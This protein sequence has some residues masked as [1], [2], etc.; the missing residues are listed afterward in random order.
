[1]AEKITKL[2]AGERRVV[3]ISTLIPNEDNPKSIS[4]KQL[5]RLKNSLQELDYILP[6][7]VNQDMRII[8]G[9]QRVKALLEEGIERVEVNV[10]TLDEEHEL[11]ALLATDQTY[12]SFDRVKRQDIINLLEERGA[13]LDVLADYFNSKRDDAKALMDDMMPREAKLEGNIEYGQVIRLGRHYLICGD[14]TDPDIWKKVR[15]IGKPYMVCTSPPYLNQRDYAQWEN[16]AHYLKDMS[17]VFIETTKDLEECLVFLNIGVDRTANLPAK[18]DMILEEDCHLSFHESICWFKSQ[19]NLNVPRFKQ[20]RSH[21]LYY[22]AFQ[23]EPCLVYIRGEPHQFDPKDTNYIHE[24]FLSDVWKFTT[25]KATEGWH[26]APY[27]LELARTA[28]QC[29]SG[30]DD[31]ILDPFIG[32]GTTFYAAEECHRTCI[33]IELSPEYCELIVRD[34]NARYGQSVEGIES[35]D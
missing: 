17:K 19:L 14:S 13:R 23:W 24:N 8:D 9:H 31:L 5:D 3:E 15:E 22:P 7:L 10:L 20:I 12:G 27:P 25:T 4:R 35:T 2:L 30:L 21:K 28:I 34:W 18:F 29:Y 16:V 11:L 33:G 6:I 26:P 1:M 32:S